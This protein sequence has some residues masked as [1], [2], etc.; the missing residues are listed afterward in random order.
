[1][2]IFIA[3]I[4]LSQ[5]YFALHNVHK[6]R[7]IDV[8]SHRVGS[9]KTGGLTCCRTKLRWMLHSPHLNIVM[10]KPLRLGLLRF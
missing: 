2:H 4:K 6:S 7:L 5:S 9:D 10:L 8:L 1:M 3:L